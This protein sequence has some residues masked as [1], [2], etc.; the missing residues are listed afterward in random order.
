MKLLLVSDVVDEVIY[1]DTIR[2]THVDVDG[3]ISC[4]DLPFDYLEYIATMLRASVYY[5]LGNHDRPMR[6]ASGEQV[7]APEGC[8]PLD[9]RI[10]TIQSRAGERLSVAGLSGSMYYGG[11][12]LQA[13]DRQMAGRVARLSLRATVAALRGRALDLLVT[14]APPRGAHEGTDLCHR[15]F[16]SFEWFLRVHRPT[17]HLHG[18]IHPSYG[19]DMSPTCLHETTVLSIYRSRTLEVAPR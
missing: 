3:V 19:I 14:H 8:I 18:H 16:R 15:G 11:T 10:T 12:A 1:R 17:I 9:G 6:R 4:G 13:T 5:V 2:K 7:S